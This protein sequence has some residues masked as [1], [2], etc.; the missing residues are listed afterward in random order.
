VASQPLAFAELLA[1]GVLVTSAIQ[2]KTIPQTLKGEAGTAGTGGGIETKAPGGGGSPGE[3]GLGTK[4]AGSPT[5]LPSYEKTQLAVAAGGSMVQKLEKYFGRPLTPKEKS[6]VE[7][8][9]L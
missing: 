7:S 5:D 9:K 2:N 6:E 3:E 4:T 1:G 8:G